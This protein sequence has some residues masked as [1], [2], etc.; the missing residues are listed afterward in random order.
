MS[1]SRSFRSSCV[2]ALGKRSSMRCLG[3]AGE[4]EGKLEEIY[5][6]NVLLVGDPN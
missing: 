1:A 6:K 3:D 2:L 5:Q 4:F